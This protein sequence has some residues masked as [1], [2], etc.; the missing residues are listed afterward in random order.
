MVILELSAALE[1]FIETPIEKRIAATK[2]KRAEP[3]T[4]LILSS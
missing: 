4:F 1:L 2:T 3:K